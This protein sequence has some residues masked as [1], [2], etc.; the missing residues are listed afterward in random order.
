MNPCLLNTFYLLQW[1]I[2]FLLRTFS[3]WP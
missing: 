1:Y 2:F 3:K